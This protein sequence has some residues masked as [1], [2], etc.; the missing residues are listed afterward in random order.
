LNNLE[1]RG[2]VESQW[3]RP[4][5]YKAID[6]RRMLRRE[7][8]LRVGMV[9]ELLGKLN[10]MYDETK[11]LESMEDTIWTTRKTG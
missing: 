4:M 3:R 11:R 1:K 8:D 5:R 7:C 2:F 6:L 10:P 9:E